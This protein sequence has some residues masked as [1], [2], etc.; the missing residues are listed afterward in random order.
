MVAAPLC[1]PLHRCHIFPESCI[2][3]AARSLSRFPDIAQCLRSSAPPAATC[4]AHM[5]AH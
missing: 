4:A 1:A 3:F 5:A 2:L